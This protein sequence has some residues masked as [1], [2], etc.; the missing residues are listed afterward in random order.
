MTEACCIN[1]YDYWGNYICTLDTLQ[2]ENIWTDIC[3]TAPEMVWTRAF[4][5]ITYIDKCGCCCRLDW[6][7]EILINTFPWEI[8]TFTPSNW[9]IKWSEIFWNNRCK[10]MVRYKT[11]WYPIS[12]EDWT[13]VVEETQQ[14]QYATNWYSITQS[15]DRYYKIYALDNDWEILSE[16]C[17]LVRN[18]LTIR[19]LLVWWWWGWGWV[20]WWG[21]AWWFIEC[22]SYEILPWSYSIVIWTWWATFPNTWASGCNWWNSS[23]NW[24]IAYWWWGWGSNALNW[25]P[26]WSWGW[27]WYAASRSWWAWCSWQWNKWWDNWW[28]SSWWWWGGAW[29]AWGN[30]NN[31]CWWYGWTWKSSNISWTTQ[32]YSWGWGWGNG[33]GCC[34]S[35]CWCWWWGCWWYWS[36]TQSDATYYWWGGWWNHTSWRWKW[37]QWIFI[38]SYPTACWYNVSWWTKYTCWSNTIHC[39][40]SNWT[41]V[42]S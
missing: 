42:I 40:T 23:F 16:Q 8:K 2:K 34:W 26:W 38:I 6:E 10:T 15:E 22:S 41:L 30:A 32:W 28:Y 1:A 33:Y 3:Y 25:C 21:W 19:F 13:L 36:W 27:A 9:D 37:Y 14:N 4:D 29:S 5:Y 35:N 18:K 39:F 7:R 20:S 12:P 11:D 17:Q 24:I 31:C